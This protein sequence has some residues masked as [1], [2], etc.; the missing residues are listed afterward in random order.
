MAEQDERGRISFAHRQGE[1]KGEIRGK[2]EGKL[3]AK[4]DAVLRLLMRAGVVLTDDERTRILACVDLATLDRW[5]DNALG[6]KSA[7]DVLT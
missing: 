1:H 4:R 5:F 2:I 7:A 6:A 3:E